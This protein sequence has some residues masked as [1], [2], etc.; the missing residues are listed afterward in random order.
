MDRLSS[1]AEGSTIS[2]ELQGKSITVIKHGT[3]FNA[4][5]KL[6]VFNS[7]VKD[8]KGCSNRMPVDF[9]PSSFIHIHDGQAGLCTDGDLWK[10]SCQEQSQVSC[11]DFLEGLGEGGE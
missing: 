2:I 11:F 8:A 10:L 5:E 7:P 6:E 1:S 4:G 3:W 9:Q